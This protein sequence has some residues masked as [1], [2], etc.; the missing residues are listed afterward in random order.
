MNDQAKVALVTG[1]SRG[2]GRAIAVALARDGFDV[3]ILFAGNEIAAQDAVKAIEAQGRCATAVQCDV[4]N[5]ESVN[6]ALKGVKAE[7]G[8][9]YAVIN[10]AGITKD[11]LSMRMKDQDFNDVIDV[12]LKGAFHV[13]RAAMGDMIRARAGRII[14]ITSVSGLMGNAG[15]ANY[16]AAKAGL[17]GLTKSLARELAPRGITVN[18]VAPGF[19]K[20]DMTAAMNEQ[21]LEGALSAVPLKRI[22]APEDIAEAVAFLCSDRASYITGSVLKV[23]GGLYI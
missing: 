9:I 23:D 4:S 13:A 16:S 20:T 2:I 7:L 3:A 8:T 22:G 17:V 18:A 11:G 19:I 21:T 1:G 6:A 15:Q 12:N 10:N 5:S 14:N